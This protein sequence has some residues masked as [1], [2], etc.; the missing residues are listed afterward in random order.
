MIAT[1]IT[2]LFLDIG[3]VLLTNGW[4]HEARSETAAHFQLDFNELNERHH[5]AFDAYE[6]GR[7]TL[8]E[9]LKR[10]VFYEKR[11]FFEND[12][13]TFMLKQSRP[14]QDTIDCF[15]EIKKKYHVKIIAVSN[16]GRELNAFR[17]KEF[18]LFEL[19][20]VFISSCF[21]HIR[22]PD[23][24]I[25]NMAIDIAQTLPEQILFIDDR[26]MFVEV[27]QSLGIHAIHYQGLETVKLQLKRFGF[28][29][30]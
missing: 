23:P 17:I 16:E 18:K 19:F 2:T 30:T 6:Q 15:K 10:I 4:G 27:A 26:S 28:S 22:K 25:F 1:K 21:V 12:F 29:I 9:Y 11:S 5:L 7:L 8:G 3:G 20:D 14:Y 13:V 24:A